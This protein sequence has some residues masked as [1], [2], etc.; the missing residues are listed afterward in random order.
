VRREKGEGQGERQEGEER[1]GSNRYLDI[2]RQGYTLVSRYPIASSFP[3]L[4][5]KN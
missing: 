1:G 4:N 2:P 5:L 3:F